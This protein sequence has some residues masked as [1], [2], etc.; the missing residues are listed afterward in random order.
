MAYTKPPHDT[1]STKTR[2]DLRKW[3]VANGVQSSKARMLRLS[4]LQACIDD[5]EA[6]D[7]LTGFGAVER[8]PLEASEKPVAA[9]KQET[10]GNPPSKNTDEELGQ[11]RSLLR[12]LAG[13]SVDEQRVIELIKKYS[14]SQKIEV[15]INDDKRIELEGHVHSALESVLPILAQGVNV[16]AVGPAGSGKT[17]MARQAATAMDLDFYFQG[18]VLSKYDLIGY[19][20]A[21]GEYVETDFRRWYENGGL[22]LLDEIDGSEPEAIVAFNAALEDGYYSFP[23]GKVKRHAACRVIAAANTYGSGKDRIYV[24]RN[25]LDASSIS[26]FFFIDINYD[27][28]LEKSIACAY[29]GEETGLKVCH[30]FWSYRDAAADLGLQLICGTRELAN[31]AKLVASGLPINT[32]VHGLIRRGLS[33]DQWEQYKMQAKALFNQKGMQR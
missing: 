11:L 10:L 21:T 9:L 23:D 1:A 30:I 12:R 33:A 15:T 13:S 7:K 27:K 25:K 4:E 16:Y 29:L 20:D 3:L 26:R 19:M 28:K 8:K 22:F 32:A 6:I 31:G 14:S 24:G 17:T 2:S 5:P 18:A